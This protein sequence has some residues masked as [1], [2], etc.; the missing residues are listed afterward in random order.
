VLLHVPGSGS[1]S[2][3]S[4]DKANLWSGS[5]SACCGSVPVPLLPDD[6]GDGDTITPKQGSSP[7]M[8]CTVGP[9]GPGGMWLGL[10]LAPLVPHPAASPRRTRSRAGRCT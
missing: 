1:G 10:G 8:V 4:P 7:R 3:R 9:V 6:T 2:R 5:D